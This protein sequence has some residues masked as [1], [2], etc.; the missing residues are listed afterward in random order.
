MSENVVFDSPGYLQD[1]II[2]KY[3]E[4]KGLRFQ[5]IV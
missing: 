4:D 3:S 1:D 2:L 5:C